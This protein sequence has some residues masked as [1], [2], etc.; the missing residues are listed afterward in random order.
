MEQK[1]TY[2]KWIGPQ[3][4]D[5]VII[6]TQGNITKIC[7]DLLSKKSLCEGAIMVYLPH[8]YLSFNQTIYLNR[9]QLLQYSTM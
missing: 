4:D 2:L 3:I 9:L 5:N 7:K 6:L 1:D 8:F